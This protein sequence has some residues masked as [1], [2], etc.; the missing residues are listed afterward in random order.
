MGT[1]MPNVRIIADDILNS[2]EEAVIVPCSTR[3]DNIGGGVDAAIYGEY[4]LVEQK[5]SEWVRKTKEK[6]TMDL[7][8]AYAV[9]EYGRVFILV[10]VPPMDEK[11]YYYCN[12]E[13]CYSNAFKMAH[14]NDCKSIACPLLGTGTLGWGIGEAFYSLYA[15][16]K[17]Y[18]GYYL[19]GRDITLYLKN[20][21]AIGY[22]QKNNW[23]I[24]F[25]FDVKPIDKRIKY[26]KDNGYELCESFWLKE[27]YSEKEML[28]QRN[29]PNEPPEH[30]TRFLFSFEAINR[31]GKINEKREKPLKEIDIAKRSGLDKNNISYIFTGNDRGNLDKDSLI[32]FGYAMECSYGMMC[33]WLKMLGM[34]FNGSERDK[35]IEEAFKNRT[36]YSVMYLNKRLCNRGFAPLQTSGADDARRE[37]AQKLDEQIKA[38]KALSGI[39]LKDKELAERSGMNANAILAIRKAK[40]EFKPEKDKIISLGAAL[41]CSTAQLEEWLK[42]FGIALSDNKRDTLIRKAFDKR[43]VRDAHELNALLLKS[44]C[45]HLKVMAFKPSRSKDREAE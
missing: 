30:E 37:F 14:E 5:W 40:A 33:S 35:F 4:P 11:N 19:Y 16:V 12:L 25:C 39:D 31:L 7:G 21:E 1:N 20:Q 13:T 29:A 41:R 32:A 43:T 17:N 3:G 9:K 44:K 27:W 8:E 42:I 24:E 15:V 10:A 36:S 28:K 2:K 22:A 23:D 26:M 34:C 38:Y 45:R 6:R 18:S